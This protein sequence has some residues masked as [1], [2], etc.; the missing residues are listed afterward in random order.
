MAHHKHLAQFS[1]PGREALYKIFVAQ[2]TPEAAFANK[3]VMTPRDLRYFFVEKTDLFPRAE[4]SDLA[5]LQSAYHFNTYTPVFAP[6]TNRL[7]VVDKTQ[8]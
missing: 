4:R 5:Y 3:A 8:L 1:Q 6:F 2:N 7:P